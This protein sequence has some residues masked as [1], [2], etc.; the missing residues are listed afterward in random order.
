MSEFFS[1]GGNGAYV[2]TAYGITLAVLI[3]NIWSA[4]STLKRN[5]R[6]AAEQRE[7]TEAPR[8]A[9]VSQL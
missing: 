2:W 7:T 1:M 5:L 6:L 9:K 8:R 3:W 4:R